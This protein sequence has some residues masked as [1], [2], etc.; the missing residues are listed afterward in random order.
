M[1]ARRYFISGDVQGVGFRYFVLREVQRIGDIKGMVRNLPDG[2]VE[3]YA[4]G[5]SENIQQLEKALHKGPGMAE[6]TNIRIE[7]ETSEDQYPDFRITI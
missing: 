7:E 4:E 3:V 1:L 5:D 6:V 2:R